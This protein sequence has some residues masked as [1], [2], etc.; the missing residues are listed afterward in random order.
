MTSRA[1]ELI[2]WVRKTWPDVPSYTRGSVF[3]ATFLRGVRKLRF[4][5]FTKVCFRVGTESY[6]AQD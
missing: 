4:E 1:V 3:L 5:A 2:E 6:D